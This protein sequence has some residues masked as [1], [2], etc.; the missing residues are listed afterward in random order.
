[1]EIKREK[2]IIGLTGPIC[3]GKGIV[4]EYLRKKGFFYTS[5]SEQVREECRRRKITITRENLQKLGDQMRKKI[6]PEV[7]AKRCWETINKKKVPLAIV[8]SIRGVAEVDFLKTK[9]NFVRNK[10]LAKR[11]SYLK[12]KVLA[13]RGSYFYLIGV[14]A[15]RG[16]RFKRVAARGRE[17]DPLNWNDFLRID[18]ADFK[19]GQ[20]KFGRDITAC[21][22]KADL[23]L[24]NNGTIKKLEEKVEKWFVDKFES[25]RNG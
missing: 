10:V 5:T 16:T 17:S 7:W 9:P 11:G 20:G 2:I 1:M 4:A 14:I 22:K 15:P 12:N 19:S 18:K 8:D 21:L 13:K 24:N 6:G 23:L 3:G 25:I